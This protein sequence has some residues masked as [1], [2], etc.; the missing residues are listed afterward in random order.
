MGKKKELK[1]ETGPI[2]DPEQHKA[3]TPE[4]IEETLETDA[5]EVQE[6]MKKIP[7]DKELVNKEALA[8]MLTRMDKLESD[9]KELKETQMAVSDKSRLQAHKTKN[10]PK[11][12]PTVRLNLWEG[13]I[14][15]G[16]DKLT[17]NLC[18]KNSAG[19]WDEELECNLHLEDGTKVEHLPYVERTRHIENVDAT[20]L[21]K[22]ESGE[23]FG[24]D[25]IP[26][27]M[28]DVV[29]EDGKELT[30]DKRFVN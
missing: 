22:Y 3:I 26:Q 2:T 12:K 14:I 10:A 25:E 7:D 1:Q 15:I 9:N 4:K 20:I 16:W 24:K 27:V 19:N 23:T 21:K 11:N 30:I 5:I 28:L 17:K 8:K 29:T 18:E 6:E 13:K